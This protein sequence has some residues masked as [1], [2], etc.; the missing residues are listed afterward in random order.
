MIAPRGLSNELQIRAI[1]EEV[2]ELY[3]EDDQY[4]WGHSIEK[5]EML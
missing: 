4:W 1:V 2:E 3:K 5:S